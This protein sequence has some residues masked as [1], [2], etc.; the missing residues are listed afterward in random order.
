M[1]KLSFL[2]TSFLVWNSV[3]ASDNWIDNNKNPIKDSRGECIRNG[4]WTPATAHPQCAPDLKPVPKAP[5]PV[6]SVPPPAPAPRSSPPTAPAA[7]VV[8]APTK[9][10]FQA[11][12]LFDFDRSVIKPEGRVILDG[13]ITSLNGSQAKYDTVIVIGH[14]D[15]IGTDEYNM[16]LGLRRAEAVKA[17]LISKG[18][19]SRTIRTSSKGEREPVADNKTAQGRAKNRRVVIEVVGLK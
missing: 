6:T 10:T 7:Q 3:F 4:F 1:K 16:R 12:T 9:V 14:T 18:I 11:E 15:S 13:F 2:L 17:Y 8:K 19:D 5:V